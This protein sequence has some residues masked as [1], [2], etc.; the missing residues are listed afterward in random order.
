VPLLAK[1][2]IKLKIKKIYLTRHGQT[3]FNSKG[4]VQ[5]RGVDS[6]LNDLGRAQASAFYNSF[7]HLKFDKLYTSTLK[8]THQSM[9]GF[10]D[11]GIPNEQLSGLDEISWGVHEG[12]EI[13]KE[14]HAYYFEMISR[15]QKGET[16][17]A[18]E[19]GESPEQLAG[20]LSDALEYIMSKKEEQ[21]I[22]IC[23]HGRAMR[24]L[25]AIML[26]YPY[27]GMDY[28]EHNNLG[29]YELSFTGEMFV[30]DTYNSISHLKGV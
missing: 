30:L 20:R 1:N 26:N 6:D 10:I 24:M 13:N 15:W 12:M 11:L 17:L 25:L 3:D 9:K 14:Q 2:R 19:G 18:I 27:Q 21:Q 28:F 16:N 22:L 29:L 7:N 8:R 5:G 23:M 4:I